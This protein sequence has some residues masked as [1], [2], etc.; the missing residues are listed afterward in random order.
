MKARQ[1]LIQT[2][3]LGTLLLA[4]PAATYAQFTYT[5][6]GA[7]IT[8]TG[9]TGPGGNII[10]PSTING[11]PVT[12]IGDDAFVFDYDVNG[13]SFPNTVTNIGYEAFL[14]SG[15]TN[16]SV[17]ANVV[18]VG[19][20]AFGGCGGL[21]EIN[22]NSE[23]P[24]YS[25]L[26]GVLFDK[27]QK[28]LLQFPGGVVGTYTIPDSVTSIGDF[29]F[30]HGDLPNVV[31]PGN[32]SRIGI[33]AFYES[34]LTNMTSSSGLTDIGAGAFQSCGLT[35][36]VVPG[37]VTNI[38]EQAFVSCP[39]LNSVTIGA[40]VSSIG[41][42]AFAD[43]PNLD[44]VYFQGNAP[45]AV[46]TVFNNDPELEYVF[47]LPGTTGWETT[48]AGIP[49]VVYS[50]VNYAVTVSVS[51]GGSGVARGAGIVPSGAPSTVTAVANI[52]Y[53][54]S[55]WT[56]NGGVMTTSSNYELIV[57]SNVSL[58]ANFVPS[59]PMT[60][61]Q[62]SYQTL[63]DSPAPYSEAIGIYGNDIVGC[64][65]YNNSDDTGFLYDG[66][67][68][69]SVSVPSASGFSDASG[70][71]GY[72]FSGTFP[73]GISGGS[74]VG[75][76]TDTNANVHGFLY[77]DGVFT[78]LDEP[79]ANG[80]TYAQGID[81]GNIV[82]S[83]WGADSHYHGFLYSDGHY[84][85]I[86]DP[87]AHGDTFASGISGQDIVGWYSDSNGAPH[88]FLYDGT[89][90]V[91]L[92]D[93]DAVAGTYACGVSGAAI[94]GYYFGQD[95]TAHGFLYYE[96]NYT[97]LDAPGAGTGAF[98]GTYVH[99]ISGNTV[100]GWY[101]NG[102]SAYGFANSLIGIAPP[103]IQFSASPTNGEPPLQVQFNS[104]TIDSSGHYI[105][106]WN[107]NFGDSGTDTSQNPSHTYTHTGVFTPTL[108]ATNDNGLVVIADGPQIEV[109]MP[110][111]FTTNNGAITISGYTGV[112]SAIVIPTTINGYP[113]ISIGDSAFLG[114]T[115]LTSVTIPSSVIN[116]GSQAFENCSNLTSVTISNGVVAVGTNAFFDTGLTNVFIPDSVADIGEGAFGNCPNLTTITVDPNNPSYS[117]LNGV[118][119]DKSQTTLI[120]FPSGW[121]GDY[122]V[123]NSV[124]NIED[125]AFASCNNLSGLYFSGDTP[126]V[127][128]NA[129]LQD[130]LTNYYLPCAN[131]WSSTFGG[132]PAVEQDW[133]SFTPNLGPVYGVDNTFYISLPM[134]D[135]CGNA[136]T[137]QI[138]SYSYMSQTNGVFK[139]ISINQGFSFF[140][141][142]SGFI[143]ISLPPV[144]FNDLGQS[145]ALIG[146]PRIGNIFQVTFSVT[147]SNE[148][149]LALNGDFATGDFTS[150]T[151]A[152]DTSRTSVLNES[153]LAVPP[154]SGSFVA[155]LATSGNT[156]Y[157]SQT[158]TTVPGKGYLVSFWL[159]N[160][161]QDPGEFAVSWA[162]NTIYD[163]VNFVADEWTN[164]TNIQLPVV[165]TGTNT[166][167][168][169]SFRD[170]NHDFGL[171]DVSVVAY[172]TTPP[173]TILSA[174]Q[175][176]ASNTNFAFQLLGPAGTNYVLQ[177][178]TN[179]TDWNSISTSSI[180]ISGSIIVS[181]NIS[182]YN[183]GFYRVYLQ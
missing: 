172:P 54:F 125:G 22:V 121:H 180:P 150:W 123:P 159:R 3:L 173:P 113:V 119:F 126:G 156:G 56:E 97:T 105:I 94:V 137:N 4:L 103:S 142:A 16:V 15:L 88:G 153:Q 107:W 50:G 145:V 11:L 120:Q 118:I 6:N 134:Y 141:T 46:A 154:P 80:W 21:N 7:A 179:L 30:A 8:I 175:F 96:G 160:Y 128:S 129:F 138:Y 74:I 82:G 58:V 149:D 62:G 31:I 132:M 148:T 65:F 131:G 77:S 136:I 53:K 112:G 67:S 37:T 92:D 87:N 5:T 63:V 167:L 182:G 91:A 72:L 81:N 135:Q 66:D 51:P 161:Y 151:L 13:V 124:T 164:W 104:P 61:S 117:S 162:G 130:N 176:A 157:L 110:F 60:F 18:N 108:M 178:S 122:I 29:A 181:N 174:P 127:G 109:F 76:Y 143:T 75:Y 93:P 69:T 114:V 32:V 98:Q 183:R 115:N 9:Y 44:T 2:L 147:A 116:I 25:S 34:G 78:N 23:N 158:L 1:I 45:S 73:T 71:D 83:Y 95:G 10:I 12:S 144:A 168:Q 41:N 20:S 36:V 133:V 70:P 49:T 17:P 64:Y 47:Y 152:G 139:V 86:N 169:F 177:A 163:E 48:F 100:V 90:Y 99:G 59:G 111:T 146:G 68:Y 85:T 28:T 171:D 89:N 43:C 33:D 165:A 42:I 19:E 24:N 166:S 55:N 101:L 140:T 14:F 102:D 27:N 40:D 39:S 57:N 155:I 35:T 38:E 79:N 52:G 84:T 26:D 106:S 170:D